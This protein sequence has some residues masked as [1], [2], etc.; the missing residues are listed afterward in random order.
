MYCAL[1]T[2]TGSADTTVVITPDT[3]FVSLYK[4]MRSPV[5]DIP[6][7]QPPRRPYPQP[8]GGQLVIVLVS[9]GVCQCTSIE[10]A[11]ADARCTTLP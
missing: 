6:D 9:Q 10:H 5:D 3:G 1:E 7:S 11:L 2:G 8:T 4:N